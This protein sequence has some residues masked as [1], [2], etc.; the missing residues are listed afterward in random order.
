MDGFQMD[1]FPMTVHKPK[2]LFGLYLTHP[3]V[4][5]GACGECDIMVLAEV[6]FACTQHHFS[7][8]STQLFQ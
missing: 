7:W 8:R 6:R 2:T 3:Q 5:Y 1:V 4:R